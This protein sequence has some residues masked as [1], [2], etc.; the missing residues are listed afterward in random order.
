MN[1]KL[2]AGLL[3]AIT[4]LMTGCQVNKRVKSPM[5]LADANSA[6]TQREATPLSDTSFCDNAMAL[7]SAQNKQLSMLPGQ[8][9]L[10]DFGEY[11]SPA[12]VI[13][14]DAGVHELAIESY[15]SSHK[16]DNA[17]LFYPVITALDA[18]RSVL[19]L[20]KPRYEFEFN[21]NVLSNHFSLPAATRYIL[22]HT[23]PEYLGMSF[24]QSNPEVVHTYSSPTGMAIGLSRAFASYFPSMGTSASHTA[25]YSDF[26]FSNIGHIKLM[27]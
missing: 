23:S 24:S 11:Q 19:G 16:S 8:T 6:Y 9:L 20:V 1:T 17:F 15:V 22:I 18:Q 13:E 21:D 3:V 12:R 5:S 4:L 10:L 25:D 26:Y 27:L 14:I 2:S 7:S